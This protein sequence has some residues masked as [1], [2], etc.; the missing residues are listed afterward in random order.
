[1]SLKQLIVKGKKNA[2][3]TTFWQALPGAFQK[4]KKSRKKFDSIK[5]LLDF[6]LIELEEINLQENARRKYLLKFFAEHPEEEPGDY[7]AE[8]ATHRIRS[9]VAKEI[10]RKKKRKKN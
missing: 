2:A 9:F 7:F 3:I 6:L 4:I 5:D 1:M 10:I 8:E